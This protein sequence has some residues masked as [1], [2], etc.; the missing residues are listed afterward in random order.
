MAGTFY[1]LTFPGAY[2]TTKHRCLEYAVACASD[3][4]DSQVFTSSNNM[5]LRDQAQGK[6]RWVMSNT[7]PVVR[8]GRYVCTGSIASQDKSATFASPPRYSG[9]P[10][11]SHRVKIT[12]LGNGIGDWI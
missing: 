6:K 11:S 2:E 7:S 5:Q 12:Q 8:G 4:F 3:Y 1:M 9:I 10:I